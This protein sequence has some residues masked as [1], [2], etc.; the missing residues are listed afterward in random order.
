MF[1]LIKQLKLVLDGLEEM[2][3]IHQNHSFILLI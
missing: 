1:L 3:S 2:F